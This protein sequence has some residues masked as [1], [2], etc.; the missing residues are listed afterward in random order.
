MLLLCSQAI[1]QQSAVQSVRMRIRAD[2][3]ALLLFVY[4]MNNVSRDV[5]QI[6][7]TMQR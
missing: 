3:S 5:G 4:D 7:Q 6:G 2:W 1:E